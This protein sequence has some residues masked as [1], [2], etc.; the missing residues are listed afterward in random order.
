MKL[1]KFIDT[2]AR[3][4]VAIEKQNSERNAVEKKAGED[5]LNARFVHDADAVNQCDSIRGCFK[6]MPM[7]PERQR[8]LNLTI[9][10]AIFSGNLFMIGNP[11][12]G[13]VDRTTY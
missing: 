13:E 1:S 4:E 6:N 9:R 12:D 5:A 10:K 11:A 7:I 8:S 2:H 3:P